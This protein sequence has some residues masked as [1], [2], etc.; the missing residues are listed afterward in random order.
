METYEF[1][2]TLR[3]PSAEKTGEQWLDQLYEAGCDD[4]TVAFGQPGFLVLDFDR[5]AESLIQAI[6]SAKTD[7]LAAVPG[8]EIECVQL[9][10]V[11]A[12]ECRAGPAPA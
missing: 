3:L 9:Y 4:A 6:V 7:A 8:S 1:L 2:I 11:E 12:S 10:M 5:R